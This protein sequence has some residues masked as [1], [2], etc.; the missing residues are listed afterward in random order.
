MTDENDLLRGIVL[1]QLK[2]QARR[3]EAKKLVMAELSKM[4]VQ[5][6]TLLQQINY[7]GQPITKLTPQEKALFKDPEI[8]IADAEESA[9][10]LSVAAPKPE[11]A[12]MAKASPSPPAPGV[13]RPPPPRMK[14]RA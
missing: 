12:A 7:L 3:S 5:S 11:S 10:A 13:R 14:W 6:D 4:Q 9:M 8:E 1:R 2:E